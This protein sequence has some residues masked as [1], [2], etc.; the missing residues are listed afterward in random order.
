[1]LLKKFWGRN[2]R[3]FSV[4][5]IH[6][7]RHKC[8]MLHLDQA[9]TYMLLD[10][11]DKLKSIKKLYTPYQFVCFGSILQHSSELLEIEWLVQISHTCTS[12]RCSC[13]NSRSVPSRNRML[14]CLSEEQP[15]IS[16]KMIGVCNSHMRCTAFPQLLIDWIVAC[17]YINTLPVTSASQLFLQCSLWRFSCLLWQA[18]IPWA[19]ILYW[20]PHGWFP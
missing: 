18:G 4:S 17:Q 19:Y 2:M 9:T 11:L 10:T 5:I 1:M 3:C 6:I 8:H 7:Y 13:S 16:V 14:S 20:E 15:K 12:H